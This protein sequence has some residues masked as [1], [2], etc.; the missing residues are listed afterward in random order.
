LILTA[1]YTKGPQKGFMHQIQ[2]LF[3]N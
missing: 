2:Q 1:A 3:E